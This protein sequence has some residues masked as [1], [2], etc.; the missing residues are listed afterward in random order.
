MLHVTEQILKHVQLEFNQFEKKKK[1]NGRKTHFKRR[2][3]EINA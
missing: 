3:N 1:K 2:R